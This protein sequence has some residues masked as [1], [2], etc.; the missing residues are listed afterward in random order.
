ML[1][2]RVMNKAHPALGVVWGL[3]LPVLGYGAER[4]DLG[5]TAGATAAVVL[6][7][8]PRVLCQHKA[9]LFPA[10]KLSGEHWTA[11]HLRHREPRVF[12]LTPTQA[13]MQTV[14]ASV[15]PRG[16]SKR[17]T[18]SSLS[19]RELVGAAQRGGNGLTSPLD[20]SSGSPAGTSQPSSDREENLRNNWMNIW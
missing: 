1:L 12:R 9:L 14:S 19:L 17:T 7:A 18:D 8:S 10:Q 20:V 16:L 4:E 13:Q 6:A 15:P 2:A 3:R 11:S 5:W